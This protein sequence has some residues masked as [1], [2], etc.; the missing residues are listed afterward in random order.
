MVLNKL[1]EGNTLVSGIISFC[2]HARRYK[3]GVSLN[4]SVC[5]LVM[6]FFL[7]KIRGYRV[8][9]PSICSSKLNPHSTGGIATGRGL[10]SEILA[11]AQAARCESRGDVSPPRTGTAV[12]CLRSTQIIRG[13]LERSVL[14]LRRFTLPLIT[15]RMRVGK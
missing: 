11:H 6:S 13:F 10:T 2:A 3:T 4:Q 8:R 15:L 7:T 14:L 12:R 9:I 1:V 5:I